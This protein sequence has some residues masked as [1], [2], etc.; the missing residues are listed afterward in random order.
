MSIDTVAVL[1]L[2]VTADDDPGAITRVLERFQNLNVL[3]R[4]VTAERATT[5]LLHVEVQI[6][7]LAE[8]ML[9]LVTNKLNS[10][11]CIVSAYWYR[12]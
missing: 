12:L 9:S 8:E 6:A 5:G 11:P 1:G 7:G 4:K 10:M 3:P 2:R